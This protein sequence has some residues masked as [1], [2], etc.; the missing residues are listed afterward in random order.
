M[1]DTKL[2]IFGSPTAGTPVVLAAPLAA[3]DLP[4]ELLVW[5]DPAGSVWASYN[6]P[7][8]LAERHHL[9]DEMPTRLEPIE[10][11]SDALGANT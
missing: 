3:L 4:L 11:I 6:S 9:P 8:Y 5:E 10:T 2:V 1:P 7:S